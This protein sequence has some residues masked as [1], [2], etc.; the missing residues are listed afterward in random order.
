MDTCHALVSRRSLAL[1]VTMYESRAL[2]VDAVQYDGK[3][4][5]T[6][7]ALAGQVNYC[8]DHVLQV[9]V[10]TGAWITVQPG[11]WVLRWADGTLAVSSDD[12][13]TRFWRIIS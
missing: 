3:D 11:F 13:F 12:F 6:I 9:R 7:A 2:Q 1:V 4:I 8:A 10:A 5:S